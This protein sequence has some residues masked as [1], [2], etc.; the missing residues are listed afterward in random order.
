MFD[1]ISIRTGGTSHYHETHEHRAPTDESVRLLK[2]MEEAALNKIIGYTKLENNTLKG[3]VY[4][5][6]DSMRME[7]TAIARFLLN[8]Q[9]IKIT[10]PLGDM[11]FER[12]EAVKERIWEAITKAVSRV[13]VGE[14]LHFE[15]FR[16]ALPKRP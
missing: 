8:G 7:T 11:M 4:V 1:A 3:E 15:E 14:L 16:D 13:I 6:R 2:E 5:T 9:E 12:I 10:I